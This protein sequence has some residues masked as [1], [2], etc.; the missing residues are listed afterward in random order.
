MNQGSGG[1]SE[2]PDGAEVSRVCLTF[3]QDACSLRKATARAA[4]GGRGAKD[5]L[6]KCEIEGFLSLAHGHRVAVNDHETGECWRG[7][8]DLTFPEHGFVWVFTDLGERKL[9]DIGIHTIWRLDMPW[10][11]GDER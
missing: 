11:C 2:M 3:G 1:F 8:V 5:S 6:A 9:L 7:S 4:S 10:A